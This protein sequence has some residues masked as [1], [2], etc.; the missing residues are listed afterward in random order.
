MSFIED[1]LVFAPMYVSLFWA[2]IFLHE[3]KKDNRAKHF[4]GYFMIAACGVYI[5]HAAFF[6]RHFTAYLLLDSLY[7]LSSLS[8]YPLFYWYVKLLTSETSCTQT[9]LLHLLPAL[10]LSV[11]SAITYLSMDNPDVYILDNMYGKKASS[12]SGT[13]LWKTQHLFYLATRAIFFMQVV[14]YLYL[15]QRRIR[16]Y[17]RQVEEFYSNIEGRNIGWAKWLLFI[18]SATAVMSATVNFIGR[19][20]FSEKEGLILFPALVFSSLLFMIGFWGYMQRH[21]I[22]D[23]RSDETE[24]IQLL[25][26]EEP[27]ECDDETQSQTFTMLQRKL[28]S[29]FEEKKIFTTPDLKIN[30]VGLL[31]KTN[32]TYISNLINDEFGCSFSDYV[33]RYRVDEV[34]RMFSSVEFNDFTLEQIAEKAGF[35]SSA[36]L[37]RIFKQFEGVTPGIYRKRL[38]NS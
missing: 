4:L 32:R 12:V 26:S 22:L 16:L 19:N 13:Y 30:Q 27:I 2:V 33:N 9:D 24:N 14:I 29:L 11:A 15:G 1:V 20:F 37:I 25:K 3:S 31:L 38:A 10:L 8:V 34:K 17:N 5:C 36:A 18:F 28:I 21:S 35:T 7:V 23:L 6:T